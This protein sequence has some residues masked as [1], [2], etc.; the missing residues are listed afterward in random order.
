MKFQLFLPRDSVNFIGIIA[1]LLIEVL[2]P[3][4]GKQERGMLYVYDHG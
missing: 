2:A 1:K 3:F 4:H